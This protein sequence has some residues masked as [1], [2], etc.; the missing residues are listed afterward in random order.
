MLRTTTQ[1]LRACRDGPFVFYVIL[2]RDE[3]LYDV[4]TVTISHTV[5][6]SCC[7]VA[8]ERGLSASRKGIHFLEV[9]GS[10]TQNRSD[11]AH[12]MPM[13]VQPWSCPNY[14]WCSIVYCVICFEMATVS[15]A[16]V[17]QPN[18]EIENLEVK[19]MLA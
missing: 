2:Y 17:L 14:K 16:R 10:D 6:F 13:D 7:V 18:Q 11:Q 9:T 1:T 3:S 4:E 12:V 8:G 5:P 19:Y 15:R